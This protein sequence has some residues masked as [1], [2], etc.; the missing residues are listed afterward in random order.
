MPR[1]RLTVGALF[2]SLLAIALAYAS[3]FVP[4]SRGG[5]PA[6][7]AWLLVLGLAG[8]LVSTMA[9]GA[10]RRSRTARR[11]TL[12]FA[13]TG[14]V[15]AGGFALALRLPP[16]DAA[17]SALFLGLPRGAALV[18]YGIGLLPLIALPTAY[19]LT[20][21]VLTLTGEDLARVRALKAEGES[22]GVGEG[23]KPTGAGG[24]EIVTPAG[25]LGDAIAGEAESAVPD[26][27]PPPLSRSED[28]VAP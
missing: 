14:L 25:A 11:L 17:T 6:W 19:V 7:A 3:A 20:F 13:F 26:S 15:V 23:A 10:A 4:A 21:D 16:G 22:G 24:Q 2:L 1:F 8:C 5:A 9:L 27:P 12:P 28:E 18:L